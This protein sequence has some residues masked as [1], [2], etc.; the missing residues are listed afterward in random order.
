MQETK[1]AIKIE[2]SIN[3]MPCMGM[4]ISEKITW[5]L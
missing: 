2:A 4:P 1:A 5:M 3:R